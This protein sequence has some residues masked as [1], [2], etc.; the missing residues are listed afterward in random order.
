MKALA[1]LLAILALWAGM[2]LP[3]LAQGTPN[4]NDAGFAPPETPVE[5][6][7]GDPLYGYIAC[8]FLCAICIF[9][10]S[11]SSRRS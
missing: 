6:D 4:P 10:V 8:G 7:G 3:A 11:K 2:S 9:A 1:R 5:D